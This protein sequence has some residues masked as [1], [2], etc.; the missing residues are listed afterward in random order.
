[1]FNDGVSDI[2]VLVWQAGSKDRVLPLTANYP[3]LG[4]HP[5]WYT[6]NKPR[7]MVLESILLLYSPFLCSVIIL[8][9]VTLGNRF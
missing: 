7:F 4:P 1:M 9:A 6:W 8:S 3:F 5:L 2:L